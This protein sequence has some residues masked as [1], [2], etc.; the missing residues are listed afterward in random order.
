MLDELKRQV[1]SGEVAPRA[2]W[3]GLHRRFR[4]RDRQGALDAIRR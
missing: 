4:N 3:Y 1:Q 2:S